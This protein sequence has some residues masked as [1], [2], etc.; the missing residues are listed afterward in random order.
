MQAGAAQGH[1]PPAFLA[2]ANDDPLF[3]KN[4]GLFEAWRAA[5]LSAPTTFGRA[6]DYQY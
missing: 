2:I 6:L 4:S 3:G 5:K 1:A